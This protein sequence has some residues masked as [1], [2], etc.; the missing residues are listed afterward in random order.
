[1]TVSHPLGCK[2]LTAGHY[3]NTIINRVWPIKF[4]SQGILKSPLAWMKSTQKVT[5]HILYMCPLWRNLD[6]LYRAIFFNSLA[7]TPSRSYEKTAPSFPKIKETSKKYSEIVWALARLRVVSGF[8]LTATSS[9]CRAS[10]RPGF[11][12]F[13]QLLQHKLCQFFA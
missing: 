9:N 10:G 13:M 6:L 4:L 2:W 1:M 7:R 3:W 5:R 11:L 12:V 8:S